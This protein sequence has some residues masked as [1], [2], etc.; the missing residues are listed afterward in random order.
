MNKFKGILI[1]TDLDGTLL[2]DDK[3]VSKENLEAIEYFK[4][5][6]G[7]FTFI[8]GRMP[9]FATDF[10]HEVGANAPFGCINGGGIYDCENNCYLWKQPLDRSALELVEYIDKSVE[11]MGIQVNTFE[12]IHFSRDNAAQERFRRITGAENINTYYYDVKEELAKILFVDF[13]G[14]KIARVKYLLDTHPR[15]AEFDYIR[16]EKTLYEILPKGVSKGSVLP[17]MA[18]LMGIDMKNTIALGDYNNDVEMLKVAGVGIA[19]SNAVPE[20]KAVADHVTVSNNE[21][22][23]AKTVEDIERGIFFS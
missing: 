18:E 4:S 15:T 21:H 22:A 16:S 23:I 9:F 14:E 1:C 5:E 10:W 8:T 7:L 13:D 20:A 17:K 3:R 11:G 6:G 12:R 19:V 2:T